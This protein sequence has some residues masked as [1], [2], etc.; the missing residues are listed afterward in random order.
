MAPVK[1]EP[2]TEMSDFE[3]QRLANIAERDALLKKISLEAQ[4]A[5]LLSKT[6]A[7]KA[8]QSQRKK[9]APKRAKREKDAAPV[10]RRSSARLAGIT[11]DSEIAKRKAEEAY[12]AEKLQIEAKR[13]RVAGD[14]RMDEI[15]VKGKW[16]AL[17]L[18]SLAT[19]G[20][21]KYER[22]FGDEDIKKTTNKDLKIMREKMS[23]LNL[24]DAWEPN[25]IRITSERI[26]TMLFHPTES[27][28]LIFAGD[29]I[30]NLGI[31][32]ASQDGPGD[33]EEQ[34]PVITTIKPHSRPLAAMYIHSSTPSKLYTASYDSS[35]RQ[36]DLEKSVATEA[37]VADDS[38]LSGVDM[39]P[40][41]PHTL[42]FSTLNGVVGRY[43]TRNNASKPD[44]STNDDES[45]SAD[46]WQL[47]D[48]KIGGFSICPTKPQYI[49]TA[50]L[51][52][53]MKVWDLRF[54]S[55]KTPRAV[56]EHISPLSVSHAAFNSVGQIATSSYDNTVK[57][58]NFGT[59]DLKSRK[60]TE[61]LTIEPDAVIDHNCQTGRWV[62]IL[63][64]QWQAAPQSSV[65][66]FCI[67]NMNRFVDIY[68]A[69]GEQLAQLG[70]EGITAVPAVSVFHPT[71]DWVVGGT[72]SGKVCLWM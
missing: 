49:A 25:R 20:P 72:G 44:S 31:L 28:P 33:D 66:R 48:N 47:A 7:P 59:F 61:T 3:K 24:W 8:G 39:S 2:A 37:Y 32:D 56:A 43:D 64:P 68:T 1:S 18:D 58:Y 70:G 4:S 10:P 29:K 16:E 35:I 45:Y 54:L 51:D 30:G 11:P 53:T 17:T 26:Y 27:K 50:S 9:A 22:T 55:K 19:S 60:S 13:R 57:L 46:E 63:R 12:E 15:G 14:L 41:D 62:T 42:Y 23:G 34:D 52:R 71:K 69:K 36:L 5:G 67:A 21:A 38:G 6:P 65:Q 40:E